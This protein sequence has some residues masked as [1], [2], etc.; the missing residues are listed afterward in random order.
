MIPKRGLRHFTETGAVFEDGSEVYDI[1]LVLICSGF[2]ADLDI[3]D[4]PG[5]KGIDTNALN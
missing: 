3:V 5:F 1:D 2:G 4:L